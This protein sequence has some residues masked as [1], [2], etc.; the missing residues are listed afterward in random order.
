[1][2]K[3]LQSILNMY[4]DSNCASLIKI[5]YGLTPLALVPEQVPEHQVDIV[6]T[7]DAALSRNHGAC[8]RCLIRD[9]WSRDQN[10]QAQAQ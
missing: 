4:V 3:R 8:T 5:A 6:L 7:T 10:G 1:M 2:L 9:L